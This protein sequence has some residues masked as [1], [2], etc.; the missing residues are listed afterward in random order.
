MRITAK[1]QRRHQITGIVKLRGVD[2]ILLG[3]RS[4]KNAPMRT[5][6]PV[7]TKGAAR[8]IRVES[9]TWA[10]PINKTV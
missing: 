5:V 7:A 3:T 6:N 1:K 2:R 9:D 10:L 4:L 8:S